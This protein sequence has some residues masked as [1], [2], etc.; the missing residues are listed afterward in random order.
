M[1]TF[2][3]AAPLPGYAVNAWIGI[4]APAK[5]PVAVVN[6]LSGEIKKMLADPGF[7]QQTVIPQGFEAWHQS[8]ADTTKMFRG[9]LDKYTKVMKDIGLK[10]VD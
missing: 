4:A 9:E 5:T 7:V 2:A 3:E 6:R 10:I 1:R 8:P